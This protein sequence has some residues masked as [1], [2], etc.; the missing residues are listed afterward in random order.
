[1]VT[2]TQTEPQPRPGRSIKGRIIATC[3]IA[4]WLLAVFLSADN[5]EWT[6]GWICFGLY[7]VGLSI[8]GAL[9]RRY[10]PSI[11]EARANFRHVETKRFDKII[12]A[13]YFPLVYVQ[14]VVAGLDAERYHW[15]SLP[16]WTIYPG[17]AVFALAMV[18]V[19]SV[20]AVN[21]FAENTVRIQT[22]R[23]HVVVTSGPYRYVRHPLYLGAI[24]MY[25]ATPLVLGSVWAFAVT[26]AILVVLV[27]RTALED[28]TLRR[29]LLGYEEFTKDTRY[30]LLPGIW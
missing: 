4:T 11:E 24:L 25:I 14:L 3:F 21:R 13:I 29:E 22:E 17:A 10:N 12:L 23:G 9:A 16:R 8:V 27:I 1:M 30:R 26:A 6:R 20:L 28:R 2:S 15:T 5:F 7:V 18:L 19:G